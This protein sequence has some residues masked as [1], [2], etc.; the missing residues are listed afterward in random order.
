MSVM[1]EFRNRV[2]CSQVCLALGIL[3]LA[4]M[5]GTAQKKAL[6][7]ARN[8]A[9]PQISPLVP[10]GIQRGATIEL[11]ITGSNLAGPLQL[12]TTIPQAN[13]TI[14]T[15][16]G[17]GKDAAK[18]RAFL[19]VPAGAPIG[20]YALRI[21]TPQGLSNVRLFCVDD[22]STFVENDANHS[23]AAA[24]QLPVPCTVAGRTGPEQSDYFKIAVAA[25]Q[26]LSFEVIGHRLGSPIDP[27]ITLYDAR[28]ERELAGG[29]NNDAAGLQTDS[30]LTYTF[31]EAG[32]Y[33]VEIR[34]VLY[35]GGPDYFYRLRI[36]DFPCA[37]APIPM[38]IR[39]GSKAAVRFA[40]P[41]TEH[42]APVDV[43]VPADFTGSV[44]SV[45]PRGANG[46]YG[47]PV[48]LAVT[49]HDEHMEQEPNNEPAKANRIT[50]PCGI[51]GRF[52]SKGDVDNYVFALKKGR[53]HVI[54]ARTHDLASPPEVYM[55]LKNAAGAE[56]GRSNP[57]TAARIEFTPS[58]DGDYI[59]SIEH[60]FYWHGPAETYHVSIHPYLP[61]FDVSLAQD[62]IDVPQGG[63][64]LVNL[65]AVRRDYSGPIEVTVQGGGVTGQ[66]IVTTTAPA[67]TPLLLL[68]T[69]DAP[70]AASNVTVWAKAK[71]DGQTVVKKASTR[72][73]LT[74]S[75]GGLFYPPSD[76]AESFGVSI[77]ERLPF[78]L[79]AQFATPETYRGANAPLTITARRE[80]GFVDDITLA[81]V[82]V[83]GNFTP[84]LKNI[85]KNQN[86]AKATVTVTDKAGMGSH[87]FIFAGKA[88]YHGQ[89]VTA[90]LPVSLTVGPPFQLKADAASLRI[91]PGGKAK[92]KV[93]ATRLGGYDGPIVIE[94]RN[95]PAN[96]TAAAATIAK[97]QVAIEVELTATDKAAL[98]AKKDV[99]IS[100]TASA[101]GNQQNSSPAFAVDVVKK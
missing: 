77:R 46:L 80:P 45:A 38:A 35:R 88:K 50:V 29:H 43:A 40:G 74:T 95:L 101:A 16:S 55:V 83:P 89:E 52:E 23:K 20:I 56:I 37:T 60:L 96:V 12:L 79:S 48:A 11:A 84:A 13:T 19:A 6:P 66:A 32:E 36:G 64:A 42:C 63:V 58:A 51:T 25:G 69:S 76:L 18:L 87:A 44:V 72:T 86:E 85:G 62:S 93:S 91:T 10:L 97:G 2:Y 59:L 75:L 94:L 8:P 3:F 78:A 82:V 7:P 53:R 81:P 34:D 54:E 24:Q 65:T 39:R 90:I 27:Q 5:P 92:L 1:S 30:R 33:V 61:D 26:R 100:G 49:D 41:T 15:D 67:T 22:L 73:T 47:W 31:K 57:A 4:T 21:A 68:A 17:N 14:P 9:A 70:F 28:T 98:G 99:T 71:I